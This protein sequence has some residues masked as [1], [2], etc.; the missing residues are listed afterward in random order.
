MRKYE[1]RDQR[2]LLGSELGKPPN[3]V[4]NTQNKTTKQYPDPSTITNH[5]NAAA[6]NHGTNRYRIKKLL[7]PRLCFGEYIDYSYYTISEPS[8]RNVRRVFR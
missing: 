7:K 4:E 2:L 1:P 5:P 3:V 6:T 8:I